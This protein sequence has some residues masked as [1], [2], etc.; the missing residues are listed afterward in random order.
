MIQR[1]GRGIDGT[2]GLGHW[3]HFTD[4][5]L[6]PGPFRRPIPCALPRRATSIHIYIHHSAAIAKVEPVQSFLTPLVVLL[7]FI[8]RFALVR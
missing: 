4:G 6:P 2:A 3:T 8:C 7:S 5:P 1:E